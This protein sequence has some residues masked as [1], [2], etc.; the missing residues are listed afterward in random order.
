MAFQ[1]RGFIMVVWCG[2]DRR[3][4]FG[5]EGDKNI[6]RIRKKCIDLQW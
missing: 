5:G 1:C 2:V 4:K 6:W 3:I